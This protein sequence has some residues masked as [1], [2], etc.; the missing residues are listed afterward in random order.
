MKRKTYYLLLFFLPP[1][2][3]FGQVAMNQYDNAGKKNGQWIE[4]L[5]SQFRVLKDSVGATYWAYNYYDHGVNNNRLPTGNEWK[6]NDSL[7]HASSS[8]DFLATGIQALNGKYK[9]Y[10][11][12]RRLLSEDSFAD[13]VHLWSKTYDGGMLV[14]LYDFTQTYNGDPMTYLIEAYED[15]GLA[16]RY[17]WR[18]GPDGWQAYPAF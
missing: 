5:N 1:F 16:V 8:T 4:Y 15:D 3:G 2:A 14:L 6:K 18:N 7:Y 13:G 17:Y 11:K 12:K 9:W 10:D